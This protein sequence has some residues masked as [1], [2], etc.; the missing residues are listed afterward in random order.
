MIKL[1]VGLGNIG[2]QYENTVHNMGFM[3]IDKVAGKFG[4]SF[5]KKECEAEIAEMYRDGEKIILAKPTTYMNK[6]GV[7]VKGLAHKYKV[8]P[9]EIIVISDDIALQPGTI[10]LRES[11]S[12]GTHNGLKSV[13]EELGVKNFNRVRVGVGRPPEFMDLADFVLSKAK[14]D[15]IQ[16]AGI[17]KGTDAVY[18]ILCGTRFDNAMNKYNQK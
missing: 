8:Q 2:K 6:S 4:I 5:K 11:G 17:D 10:R 1:V 9:D 12:A 15:S 7:A 13:I 3:V 14:L 16:L 18:D